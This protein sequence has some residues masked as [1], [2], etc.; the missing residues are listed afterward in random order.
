MFSAVSKP[1][2]P[3]STSRRFLSQSASPAL[4]P[5]AI[6]HAAS[7]PPRGAYLCRWLVVSAPG[8]VVCVVLFMFCGCGVVCVVC[9]CVRVVCVVCVFS[10]RGFCMCVCVCVCVCVCCVTVGAGRQHDSGGK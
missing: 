2:S 3:G 7:F 8:A 9:V 4:C 5:F 6:G 1:A 10:A